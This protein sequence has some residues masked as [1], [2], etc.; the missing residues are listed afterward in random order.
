MPEQIPDIVPASGP[1]VPSENEGEQS[2][3]RGADL[4]VL[5]AEQPQYLNTADA[6]AQH[7]ARELL[8]QRTGTGE[9]CSGPRLAAAVGFSTGYARRLI[10]QW[11]GDR[12]TKLNEPRQ[13]AQYR[14]SRATLGTESA[15][16][17]AAELSRDPL[18]VQAWRM[19]KATG[20]PSEPGTLTELIGPRRRAN[21]DSR[22]GEFGPGPGLETRAWCH[23]S[24]AW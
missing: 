20:L 21:A 15:H 17:A 11:N 13:L 23:V 9:L 10:R 8:D 3:S 18:P 19:A 1:S 14:Y 12:N 7:R 2:H 5:T 16:T 6:P 24:A 4:A 22:V